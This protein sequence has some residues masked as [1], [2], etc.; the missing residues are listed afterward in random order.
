MPK[1][2]R[3]QGISPY[4][5]LGIVFTFISL[6]SLVMLIRLRSLA[7]STQQTADVG[8]AA[9][10]VDEI[11]PSDVSG[12]GDISLPDAGL[13]VNEDTTVNL[14]VRGT[15]SDANGFSNLDHVVVNVYRSG[16]ANGKDCTPDNNDCY[17]ANVSKNDLAPV[18]GSVTLATFEVTI[19]IQYYADPTDAG[20]QYEEESWQAEAAVSDLSGGTGSL[21]VGFEVQSL[22]AFALMRDGLPTASIN[23]GTLSLNATSAQNDVTFRNTGNRL[24][25]SYVYAIDDFKS[26]LLGFSDILST[27]V[28]FSLNDQ[29]VY[30]TG[31]D[32]IKKTDTLMP[33]G[34]QQ[35]TD[36][37]VPTTKPAYFKL[38]MP[39]SGVNGTYT[40]VVVFTAHAPAFIGSTP[41]VSSLSST[42]V[43]AGSE[44]FTLDVT[45]ADFPTDAVLQWNGV[46]LATVRTDASHLSAI[47]P[48]ENLVTGGTVNVTVLNP[49][50]NNSSAAIV[51]TVDNGAPSLASITPA[52]VYLYNSQLSLELAGTNFSPNSQVKFDGEDRT[53]SYVSPTQLTAV[54]PASDMLTAGGHEILV[55]SPPPGG[56][57]T[58]ALTFTVNNPSPLLVSINPDTKTVLDGEFTLTLSG[59][60]YLPNSVVY[61]G[62]NFRPTF[63]DSTTQLRATIYADDLTGAGVK[64]VT[65]FNP[66]PG[67]GT[68][69]IRTLTVSNPAPTLS[70]ISPSVKTVGDSSFNMTLS[71]T[72]FVPA[73]QVKLDSTS[74]TTTWLSGT[75]LRAVVGSSAMAAAGSH[76]I[77]VVNGTPG[78][79]TSTAKTF[80]V[81]NP[82]PTISGLSPSSRTAGSASFTLTVN[83]T[84]FAANSQIKANGS[85]LSTTYVSATQLR[86]TVDAVYIASPGSLAITVYSP[87]T[88]LTSD[89]YTLPIYSSGG[90]DYIVTANTKL[91]AACDADNSGYTP[92]SSYVNN[93]V[94]LGGAATIAAGSS[95]DGSGTCYFGGSTASALEI[96]NSSDF[97]FETRDFTLDFWMYPTNLSGTQALFGQRKSSGNAYGLYFEM[98]NGTLRVY[99]GNGS[100]SILSGTSMGAITVNAWT[101]I[102]VSRSGG[103]FYFFKNGQN[104]ATVSNVTGSAISATAFPV[105][106][107]G[108]GL[109]SGGY[110][111]ALKGYMDDIRLT[112]DQA[113][114]TS[115]FGPPSSF[116]NP[117]P[118][119]STISPSTVTAGSA[120][121]N[122]TVNGSNFIAGSQVTINGVNRNT[123]YLSP[124]QLRAYVLASDI[125]AAGSVNVVVVNS[126]PGGGSSAAKT[127]TVQ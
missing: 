101:H 87:S 59:V 13:L 93:A 4:L 112:M 25:D 123:T 10:T 107:G 50:T 76:N 100:W 125:A 70:S 103:V 57:T 22:A 108:I 85:S 113:L 121:F 20:S 71:G 49:T 79:G 111:Y 104:V 110:S 9:P 98:A 11:I 46:S 64:D 39:A 6:V 124:T 7:D 99:A 102:A 3:R 109:T 88:G 84:N 75:S 105:Y 41:S 78:G 19:P 29:F 34:L 26:D 86:A 55:I 94:F 66:G 89:P 115:D 33:L 15:V 54:I 67:G 77:T 119:I 92:D 42:N 114:W 52:N 116:S 12:S 43:V 53:T 23:Y 68:S 96:A 127:L 91:L 72:G 58:T 44:G 40:N 73:S 80:T 32:S 47:V 28:H 17:V 2:E 48:A 5:I 122:L 37:N 61:L 83:G 16:A 56:G 62:S 1:T 24:V 30:G 51:F 95:F 120:G 60:D 18:N 82:P 35:Q 8:N 27:A 126:S 117:V 14:Y 118:T 97:D 90:G 21:S 74:L 69:A 63:F 36:D 38:K 65:V 45:G 31:D 81:N 106:I